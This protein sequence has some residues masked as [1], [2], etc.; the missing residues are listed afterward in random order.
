MHGP[1]VNWTQYAIIPP[2]TLL[3]KLV[4]DVSAVASCR[5][6]SIFLCIGDVKMGE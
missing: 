5:R 2:A 4:A 6:L 1:L 3:D